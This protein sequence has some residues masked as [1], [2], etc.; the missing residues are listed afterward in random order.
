[1]RRISYQI[2][3]ICFFCVAYGHQVK[4]QSGDEDKQMFNNGKIRD[5][6]M[7]DEALNGW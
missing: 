5:Q 2:Y 1:M 3:I 6:K 4:A 7:I